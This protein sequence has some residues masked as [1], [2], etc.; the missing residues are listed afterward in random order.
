MEP[1]RD[2]FGGEGVDGMGV[3]GLRSVDVVSECATAAARNIKEKR[4]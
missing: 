1:R 3:V 2:S 4:Q